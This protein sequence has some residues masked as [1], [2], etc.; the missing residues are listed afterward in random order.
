MLLILAGVTVATLTGK[1]GLLE[2]SKKS[3]INTKLAESY[4]DIEVEIT[5]ALTEYYDNSN[6]NFSSNLISKLEKK[7]Y[8]VDSEIDKDGQG[9]LTVQTVD[10]Y[11][12][13]ININNNIPEAKIDYDYNASE[14]EQAVNL[15]A[16]G[17][18]ALITN[19]TVPVLTS[20]TTT[21]ANDGTYSTKASSVYTEAGSVYG[22][23]DGSPNGNNAWHSKANDQNG[24]NQ[25]KMP[26]M[27]QLKDFYLQNRKAD[28][29]YNIHEIKI[30][31]SN[32]ELDWITIGTYTN[33]TNASNA[34]THFNVDYDYGDYGY[35]Y[36]RFSS[37]SSY[38][39]T[40]VII[41]EL[42]LNGN[43]YS[44]VDTFKNW[45]KCLY[46]NRQLVTY[47]EITCLI[48]YYNELSS[49]ERQNVQN[50]YAQLL[51]F[52]NQVL[53]NIVNNSTINSET[54]NFKLINEAYNKCKAIENIQSTNDMK[55]ANRFM[56][57]IEKEYTQF[58][59]DYST[60]SQLPYTLTASTTHDP[61]LSVDKI[62][63][64]ATGAWDGWH[65]SVGGS[66]WIQFDFQNNVIIYNFVIYN[67]DGGQCMNEFKLQGL[68]S[69]GQWVDLQN[70][71]NVNGSDKIT[72]FDVTYLYDDVGFRSY[73]WQS[74][75]SY[76]S[77]I[78]IGDM[79][80]KMNVIPNSKE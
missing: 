70:F 15:D 62:F 23:F 22:A 53:A 1:N 3:A 48:K 50:S 67:R 64:N 30:E 71:K 65:S 59:L 78:S 10:E 57:K 8:T 39:N 58:T 77:Y 56:N 54:H 37:V 14:T 72:S 75:S 29:N 38:S 47:D 19:Y 76:D 25:I 7:G 33:P 26:Y 42:T 61:R 2:K 17:T 16:D 43:K 55:I 41:G 28:Y 21:I 11:T 36:Y 44:K 4:E 45:I 51:I 68:N 74:I 5:T 40:Y 79:S 32:N 34:K 69:S 18:I 6:N 66:Q 63:D 24:W 46:N 12:I 31:A 20:A 35:Q 52:T 80:I 13:L 9:T 49:E 27:F 60:K 73:R